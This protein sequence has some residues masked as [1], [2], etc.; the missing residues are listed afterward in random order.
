MSIAAKIRR[1][2]GPVW[3]AGKHGARRGLGFHGPVGPVTRPVFGA[4]YAL[5]VSLRELLIWALR[6]FWY[7]PLFRSQCESVGEGFRMEKL[8]YLTGRG[9]IV[10]G[11]NVRLSGRPSIGFS[12]C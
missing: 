11:P 7:E 6:F 10:I 12:N 4:L 1:G 2:E 8:P 3:G 9:R 5:H